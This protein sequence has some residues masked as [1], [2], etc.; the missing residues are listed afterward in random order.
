MKKA[1]LIIAITL[2]GLVGYGGSAFAQDREDYPGGQGASVTN[3]YGRDNPLDGR[4]DRSNRLKLDVDHL[5][6]MFPHVE[7]EMRAYHASPQI[8][9]DYER[10]VRDKS[11]LKMD[12]RTRSTDVYK[13]GEQVR[14]MHLGLHRIEEQIHARPNEYYQW[15]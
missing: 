6:R 8:R 3:R 2:L 7:K 1:V 12:L 9:A 4:P 11:R 5:N 15:R 13:V 14:Q 10:L